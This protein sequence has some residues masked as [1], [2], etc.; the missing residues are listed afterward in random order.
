[1]IETLSRRRFGGIVP[2]VA[3]AFS[4]P[5]FSEVLMNPHAIPG[6]ADHHAAPASL[7]R[8]V[9][10]HCPRCGIPIYVYHSDQAVRTGS[11]KHPLCAGI[12]GSPERNCGCFASETESIQRPASSEEAL[13]ELRS[14]VSQLR[15]DIANVVTAIWGGSAVASPQP[16]VSGLPDEE[17]PQG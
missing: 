17:E 10:G 3:P 2:E 7:L 14:Q 16:K 1:M 13:G 11:A 5:V 12:V 4:R 9:S 8:L 6:P 15:R